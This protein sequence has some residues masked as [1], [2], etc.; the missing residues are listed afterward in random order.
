[1]ALNFSA[2]PCACLEKS[3]VRLTEG[4]GLTGGLLGFR[5]CS[6]SSYSRRYRKE[7]Q[8]VTNALENTL[9]IDTVFDFAVNNPTKQFGKGSTDKA[10]RKQ[11]NKKCT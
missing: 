2:F 10:A 6:S 3:R 4:L 8:N 1:M 9:C 5:S 11:K 7:A